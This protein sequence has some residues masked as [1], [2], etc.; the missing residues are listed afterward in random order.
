MQKLSLETLKFLGL[1][2]TVDG[3][4]LRYEPGP[5]GPVL[6]V[7]NVMS[8]KWINAILYDPTMKHL[9]DKGKLLLLETPHENDQS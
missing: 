9:A 1:E 4:S 7:R 8:G 2:F 5:E 3:L 6:K